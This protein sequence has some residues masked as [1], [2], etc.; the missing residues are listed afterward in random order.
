MRRNA[1]NRNVGLG[2]NIRALMDIMGDSVEELFCIPVLS[3]KED[4]TIDDIDVTINDEFHD[5]STSPPS[6][7]N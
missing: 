6:T 1:A 2:P 4:S 5:A 7:P 3:D